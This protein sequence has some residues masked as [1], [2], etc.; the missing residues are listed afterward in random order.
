M[1][2]KPFENLN[3]ENEDPKK[4]NLLLMIFLTAIA[5]VAMI[6]VPF[7][8][9]AGLAFLP[10][11][12]TLLFLSNRYRDAIICAVAGILVL[13]VFNY[14]LA[15]MLLAVICAVAINYKYIIS[16]NKKLSYGLLTI[17]ASFII[18]LFLFLLIDSVIL[19]Q[20]VVKGMLVTY[21]GYI[22]NL[23]QDP[24]L[25]NYQSLFF[26]DS[27]QLNEAISQTQGF[28]KYM[29]ALVPGIAVVF[30]GLSA[31]LNY[32]FSFIIL[33]KHNIKLT[34]MPPFKDWDLRWH[35]CWGV[36]AGIIFLI[37]PKFNPAYDGIID[38]IG[39][40]VIIIFG[41]LYMLLGAAVL[42]GLFDKFN[43]RVS[44]RVI[45]IVVMFLLFGFGALL[46]LVGLIDIW[47]NF[48]KLN[49]SP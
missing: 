7:A 30:F 39:Y 27:A 8:G 17:F 28:L 45:I 13:F 36:I 25:K 23:N 10:V 31:V 3:N 46:P 15:I 37:I 18:A 1:F 14:I 29:P 6:F 33:K 34:A 35:Y 16:R 5:L 9:F 48:R 44:V 41:L 42:W 21:N 19:K 2:F 26:S 20:N 40:N 43:V 12:A 47:A 32:S 22:D 24:L 49:R 11:P 4:A 38:A